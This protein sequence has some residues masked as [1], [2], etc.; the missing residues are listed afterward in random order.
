MSEQDANRTTGSTDGGSRR[1][2]LRLGRPWLRSAALV[3]SGLIAGG[4]LAGAV[5]AGAADGD[6]PGAG[7]STSREHGRGAGEEELTGE[8]ATSVEE[9]VLA[10]YPDAEVE[11]LET[12][13]DGVYEAHLV[14][15]DGEELTVELDEEFAITGTEEGRHGRGGHGRGG[16]V[17]PGGRHGDGGPGAG[18]EELTG[19]TAASV[20]A[21]VLAEYPDAE[22]ERL[23][24]DADGVHEAHIVTADGEHLTVELDEEFAI[25]GTE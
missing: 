16:H 25:T 12:D 7:S 3:G 18:E 19:E 10:E 22:V 13:A 15:A 14:T 6:G 4:I 8:T 23:E 1:A 2:R 11:R 17:G 20:E 21:A 24:T 5:T 9:A